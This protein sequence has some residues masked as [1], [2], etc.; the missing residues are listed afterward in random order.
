MEIKGDNYKLI[1]RRLGSIFQRL[2]EERVRN[3]PWLG[4]CT[5]SILDSDEISKNSRNIFQSWKNIPDIVL[6][7][8]ESMKQQLQQ[9]FAELASRKANLSGQLTNTKEIG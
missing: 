8:N 3:Q 4:F 6:S 7:R 1:Q 9:F 5:V 2:Y